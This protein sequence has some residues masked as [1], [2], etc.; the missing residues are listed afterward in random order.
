MLPMKR[1][2]SAAKTCVIDTLPFT[3]AAVPECAVRMNQPFPNVLD[4]YRYRKQRGV[5]LGEKVV[6]PL[7]TLTADS[8]GIASV[9]V[10]G[11]CLN[12]G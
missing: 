6:P 8:H 10:R 1:I 2:Y 12:D 11:S 4:L 7:E 3:T 5:N 9:Q